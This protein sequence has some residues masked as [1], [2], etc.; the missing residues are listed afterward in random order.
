M[1]A[2]NARS[3]DPTAGLKELA[4]TEIL[5]APRSLT[6]RT[7][8]DAHHVAQ[9]WGPR[10]FTNPVC[11]WDARPGGLIRIDMRAPDGTVVPMHGV[12]HEV[13][14]PEFLDFTTTAYA[15]T[16]GSDLLEVRHNVTF[17]E[18][19][20]KTKLTL[21]SRVVKTTAAT[22]QPLAGMEAGWRQ[23]FDRLAELLARM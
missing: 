2:T 22:A 21:Q 20:G 15:D 18:Q 13:R 11:Q 9:W 3:T 5:N 7:W 23:S 4:I 1:P 6:W 8:T 19:D 17:E 14:E 16:E 12:F 10:E